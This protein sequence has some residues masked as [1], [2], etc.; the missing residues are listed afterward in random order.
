MRCW[1]KKLSKLESS[2]RRS[3]EMVTKSLDS[4]RNEI[5]VR[6]VITGEQ[7]YIYPWLNMLAYPTLTKRVIPKTTTTPSDSGA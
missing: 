7:K 2:L 5:K 1:K 6:L 4:L 3:M